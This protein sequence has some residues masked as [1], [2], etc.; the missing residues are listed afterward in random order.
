MSRT[1]AI[2]DTPQTPMGWNRP[3]KCAGVLT[4]GLCFAVC[5]LLPFLGGNHL[6]LPYL[7]I[8]RFW[9]ETSF[10]ITLIVAI[11]ASGLGGNRPNS[12][13]H[14]FLFYFFPF[15]LV[16]A[17]SA[18]YTWSTYD[19]ARELNVLIWVVAVVYLCSLTSDSRL[20]LRALVWGSVVSVV[21]AAF[22]LKVLFPQ[23]SSVFTSGWYASLLQ[24]KPV[25]F[26]AF[27][28]EN[29]LGGYLL[30]TLPISAFLSFTDKK[31]YWLTTPV[32]LTG[33]LL[34]LSRLSLIVMVMQLLVVCVIFATEYNWRRAAGLAATVT[35]SVILF[36]LIIFVHGSPRERNIEDSFRGKTTT[37]LSQVRTLNSRTSIWQNGIE[38]FA[39]KP[40]IGYGAGAFEYGFRKHFSGRLYTKYAHS[41]AIRTAVE[42]G[43]LG[44]MASLWYL[45]GIVYG[46]FK[47]RFRP[48]LVS[49][50][51]A[52]GFLFSLV[53]CALD[54]AAF[55]VTFA[56]LSSTVLGRVHRPTLIKGRLVFVPI[57]LLLVAS[58][59]FTGRAG[60]AKKTIQ[61]ASLCEETGSLSAALDLYQEA[62]HYIPFDNEPYIRRLTL[63]T[64]TT[65]NAGEYATGQRVADAVEDARNRA[66]L[67]R[68]K[69]S[70]LCF[71][72]ALGYMALGNNKLAFEY[73]DKA[74][75]L[76]PASPYYVSRAVNWYVS[77]GD[78]ERATLLVKHFEPFIE[79][80]RN[81]SNPNGLYIYR[82]RELQAEIE[83]KK[84]CFEKALLIAKNNL[85]SA[86]ADEFVITSYKTREYVRKEW[87]L[88]YLSD[89]LDFYRSQVTM[90]REH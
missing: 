74:I 17:L 63:L 39:E 58:F 46:T 49:I 79:N 26:A 14:A 44:V 52:G 81:W 59:A 87:L 55:L 60:L 66:A 53:D 41:G 3:E 33:I 75:Q 62:S 90:M 37:A 50:A 29:M 77:A 13:L 21:F 61:E 19:T 25:P 57:L 7:T 34:S 2:E 9:I 40:I 43:L 65:K 51:I 30:L 56:L 76:Y 71:A 35:A 54:T 69:D 11:A 18:I 16:S 5:F 4:N 28:S 80:I 8:D 20:P 1:R 12:S 89:R 83:F 36:L 45:F 67:A 38:A 47:S 64:R 70:E 78:L 22:Q 31:I 84:G 10:T 73:V 42:L 82:L 24:E 6:A 27:L 32:I 68:D 15:F 86:N 48:A 23:M 72:N 85:Q 88:S